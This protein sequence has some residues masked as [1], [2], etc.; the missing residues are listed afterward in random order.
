MDCRW[1]E[2]V[3]DFPCIR[4]ATLVPQTMDE[5]AATTLFL[6]QMATLMTLMSM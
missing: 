4:N 6:F 3:K 1:S 2:V 5:I